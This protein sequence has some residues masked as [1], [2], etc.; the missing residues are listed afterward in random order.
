MLGEHEEIKRLLEENLKVS[1]DTHALLEK[2]HRMDLYTFWMKFLWFAI[3]IGLPF[4]IFYF[5]LGPYLEALGIY[6]EEFEAALKNLPQLFSSP[7]GKI[8]Q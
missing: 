5:F 2:M 1:K 8:M 4:V 3:I 6:S 7:M